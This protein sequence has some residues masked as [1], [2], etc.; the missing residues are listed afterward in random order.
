MTDTILLTFPSKSTFRG[1]PSLVLSGV[2]SRL[3]LPFERTDDLQLAVLSMLDASSSNDA[4]VEIEARDD[5]VTVSVGPLRPEAQADK[6]LDLVL[7]RLTDGVE[8][9]RRGEDVWLT[10]FVARPDA[11]QA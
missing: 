10:V 4:S 2:G 1:V 6:G 8:A 9:G 7:R 5:R 11:P 3:D